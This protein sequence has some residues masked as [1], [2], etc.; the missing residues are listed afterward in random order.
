MIGGRAFIKGA[1]HL[2][3]ETA[4]ML[5]LLNKIRFCLVISDLSKVIDDS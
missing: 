1:N 4:L 5:M 3:A 2:V